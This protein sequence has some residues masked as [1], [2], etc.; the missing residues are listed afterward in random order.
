MEGREGQLT[1]R[2]REKEGERNSDSV[3]GEAVLTA[4]NCAQPRP[5]A[6]SSDGR[7]PHEAVGDKHAPDA[8]ISGM[9]SRSKVPVIGQ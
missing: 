3:V 9:V 7:V 8:Q 6:G 1:E 4:Y 2:E 5:A